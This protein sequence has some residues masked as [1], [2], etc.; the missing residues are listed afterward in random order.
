MNIRNSF[1]ILSY[2]SYERNAKEFIRKK[3][4]DRLE[5]YELMRELRIDYQTIRNSLTTF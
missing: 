5:S 2:V 1:A 4:Y 3:T